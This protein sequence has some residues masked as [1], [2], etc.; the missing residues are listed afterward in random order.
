MNRICIETRGICNWRERLAKPETQW[1]RRY[2]A[3]ETAVSWETAS[4]RPS[5][6]PESIRELFRGTTFGEPTLLI[7]VAEHKVPLDGGR[8]DSQCDVWALLDT[9]TGGVSLSVEAKANEAFGQGNES[10]K[11]W[12]V[13]GESER[14]SRNREE[15]WKHIAEHLPHA[16]ADAYT[17]VPYQLLHRCAAAV[18]EAQRFRT[19]N[20]AF[21]VQSFASKLGDEPSPN[22][23]AFSRFCEA[24]SVNAERG[25]MRIAAVE[26]IRL[27]IGWADC[28]FATDSEVAAIA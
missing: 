23:E 17:H 24:V 27:G 25:Q 5:G 2:S 7:A 6:L 18:I 3:F 8:A 9:P 10:L 22:F 26:G 16:R 11:D 13:A 19:P 21:I 20:A 12:L 15:R 1:R 28:P 4:C 14:S